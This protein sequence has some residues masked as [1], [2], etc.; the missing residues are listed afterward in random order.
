M[1]VGELVAGDGFFSPKDGA[2]IVVK[3]VSG[4]FYGDSAVTRNDRRNESIQVDGHRR[5]DHRVL[6][7]ASTSRGCRP[8]VSG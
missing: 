6:S 5:L 1:L 2:A 7:S 4:T 3:C 8:R